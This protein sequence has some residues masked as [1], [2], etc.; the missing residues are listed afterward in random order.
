LKNKITGKIMYINR[1]LEA[2]INKYLKTPEIIAVT[3]ARQVGKTT[4]LQQ[5]HQRLDNSLFITFEDVSYRQMFDTDIE[6]FIELYIKPYKYIFMDEFQ[7]ANNGGQQLKLIFD[8]VRDKK[9]FIS[10]SSVLDLTI[11][12]VKHL[13]GRLFAFVLHPV[14]FEEFLAFKNQ[15]LHHYVSDRKA[16][17]TFSAIMLEKIYACLEEYIVYGGY[18]RVLLSPDHEE[19]KEV[20]RNILNVY[21]LRDVRD[22]IGLADDYKMISLMKALSLQTGNV[23][24]YQELSQI[25][26]LNFSSLKK[27]LNLLEKTYIIGLARPFFTNKR[28]ELVKNPK[29]YF[30]DTGLRHAVNDDFRPT[31]K[32]QDKGALWENFIYAEL[33]KEGIDVKYWRTKSKAEVDFIVNDKTPVEVKSSPAKTAVGKSLYSYIEKYNPADAYIFTRKTEEA[34]KIGKTAVHFLHH[35]SKIPFAGQR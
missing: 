13:A 22:L 1:S 34:F 30:H 2:K 14:S 6:A 15:E 19:K 11:H 17:A 5:I 8:T 20:L 23:I 18:P 25:T 35:F 7:Y 29:V 26:S 10:G 24:S 28:I 16:N 31:E 32:R 12:A 27:N 3:G 21:L 33:I 9:I 4:L